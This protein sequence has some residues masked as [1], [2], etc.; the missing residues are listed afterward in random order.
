MI[1]DVFQGANE[2]VWRELS[3]N[4]PFPAIFG[5]TPSRPGTMADPIT[6]QGRQ[7]SSDDLAFI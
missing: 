2:W 3:A 1:K 6:I 4:W 5:W 7:L